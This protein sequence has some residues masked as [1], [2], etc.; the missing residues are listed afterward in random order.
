MCAWSIEQLCVVRSSPTNV[1]VVLLIFAELLALS[2]TM[3]GGVTD[4]NNG[5]RS[6]SAARARAHMANT[7][8]DIRSTGHSVADMLEPR[9]DPASPLNEPVLAIG[10]PYASTVPEPLP[11]TDGGG[12]SATCAVPGGKA[13]PKSKGHVACKIG[14]A[15]TSGRHRCWNCGAPDAGGKC[16]GCCVAYYCGR[17]CQKVRARRTARRQRD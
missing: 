9:V 6:L 4:R 2:R 15:S 10:G 11:L 8:R 16:G 5:R 7:S 13:K 3:A 12:G 14:S 1:Y 17:D